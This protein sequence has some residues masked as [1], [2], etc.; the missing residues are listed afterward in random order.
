MIAD[1]LSGVHIPLPAVRPRQRS[2]GT[3]LPQSVILTGF[4]SSLSRHGTG[5]AAPAP[6][7]RE[8]QRPVVTVSLLCCESCPTML[9]H[10]VHMF[11][12][13]LVA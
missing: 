3:S 13:F 10:E 2:W 4:S 11:G 7:L 8:R 1:S 6:Y 9:V 5:L 12:D